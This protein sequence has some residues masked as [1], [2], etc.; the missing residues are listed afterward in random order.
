MIR[1]RSTRVLATI[2]V[3][4]ALL[5]AMA[6]PVGVLAAKPEADATATAVLEKVSPSTDAQAS[7]IGYDISFALEPEETSNLAQLYLMATTPSGWDLWSVDGASRP[8]CDATGTDLF[9]SFGAI[10][11]DDDPI[12]LTVVYKVG[13]ET[14]NVTIDFLFNTTGVAGDKKGKSHGDAYSA[15]ATVTVENDANFGASYPQAVGDVISDSTALSRSNPQ[16]TKVFAP[17]EDIIVT[18][19]E[20]GS[21]AECQALFGGSCF[22]Q[23]SVLNVANGLPFAGGFQAEVGYNLN[24]PNA[25]IVHFFDA[26]VTDPETGL[27]YEELG[28]CGSTPVAPCASVTTSG[29]Q[30][31][32]TVYLLQNGKIFGH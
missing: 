11:A 2:G 12:T 7:Y 4:A 9:C 1:N 18:V 3:T 32:V 15:P 21:L 20:D 16:Y 19:G 22:G 13:T 14:G 24:R 25:R 8:G 30:T 28:S 31:F 23:A 6:G 26:G 17:A 27:G 5:A 29:G 10:D